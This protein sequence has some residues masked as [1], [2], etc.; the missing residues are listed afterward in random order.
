MQVHQ[1]VVRPQDGTVIL[2]YLDNM[3]RRFSLIFEASTLSSAAAL[4]TECA[5]RLPSDA[6]HPAKGEIQK[7]IAD[8]ESRLAQ[9]KETIGA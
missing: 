3:E 2:L 9:L 1:I 6:D 4:V 7:E 8:L 5:A